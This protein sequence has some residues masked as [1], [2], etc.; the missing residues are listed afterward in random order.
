MR[1]GT[2][3]GRLLRASVPLVVSSSLLVTAGCSTGSNWPR[4]ASPGMRSV[5]LGL[6]YVKPGRPVSVGEMSICLTRPG[7]VTITGVKPVE[8]VGQVTVQAYAVRPN[9]SMRGGEFLGGDQGTLSSHGF[10]KSH[11]VDGVCRKNDGSTSYELGLQLT[12]P[13]S[14]ATGVAGWDVAYR[15]EGHAAVLRL[16]FAVALCSGVA[17]EP[18]CAKIHPVS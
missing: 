9:P 1:H 5:R 4:L 7:K 18:S 6:A 15:S 16:P 14:A 8:P 17:W 12:K 3:I 2:R 13:T 10:T 11:L